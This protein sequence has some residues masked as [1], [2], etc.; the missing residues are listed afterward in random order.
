MAPNDFTGGEEKFAE[1]KKRGQSG[2][3][4][5]VSLSCYTESLLLNVKEGWC[6]EPG[7]EKL[8]KKGGEGREQEFVYAE[9]SPLLTFHR[10][11]EKKENE[12]KKR[13][14][15]NSFR[16]IPFPLNHIPYQ[17]DRPS[18][19]GEERKG[20]LRKKRERRGGK[21]IRTKNTIFFLYSAINSLRGEKRR[22][23]GGGE[24][25]KGRRLAVFVWFLFFGVG[26]GGGEKIFTK[27]RE[28]RRE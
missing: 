28:K 13:K 5:S 26:G 10:R 22:T 11:R 23:G 12:E 24:K 6:G 1:K 25:K 9:I 14:N 2:T 3:F 19:V 4:R 27:K 8:R 15:G 16:E 20:H 21:K 17:P 18:H 7:K